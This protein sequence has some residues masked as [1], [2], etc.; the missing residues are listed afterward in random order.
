MQVGDGRIHPFIHPSITNSRYTQDAYAR[1][2]CLRRTAADDDDDDDAADDGPPGKTGG[3]TSQASLPE[4]VNT[5]ETNVP[6]PALVQEEQKY[7]ILTW[8]Q[9]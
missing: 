2:H 3:C 4:N 5:I 7:R 6:K 1:E 9:R 8:K